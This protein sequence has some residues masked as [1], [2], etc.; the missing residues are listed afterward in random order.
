MAQCECDFHVRCFLLICLILKANVDRPCP[1]TASTS[2]SQQGPSTPLASFEYDAFDLEYHVD[3]QEEEQENEDDD[4]EDDS[5][6]ENGQAIHSDF[7]L[8]ESSDTDPEF[9][10][11]SWSFADIKE[12]EIQSNQAELEIVMENESKDE[13]SIAP[14][15]LEVF[16]SW[17]TA[18]PV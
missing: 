9:F 4:S 3:Y 14:T 16:P 6:E 5:S 15:R 10:D 18:I 12:S 1:S 7:R 2:C 17:S 13:V 8:L 11:T